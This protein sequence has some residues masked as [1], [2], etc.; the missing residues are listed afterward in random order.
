ME[1]PYIYKAEGRVSKI[2]ERD[3]WVSPEGTVFPRRDFDITQIH[4]S[5]YGKTTK[6]I[7][8]RFNAFGKS[9]VDM[10]E[11][12]SLG[13]WVE[14]LFYII[15]Y[16]WNRLDT[17]FKDEWTYNNLFVYEIHKQS[18]YAFDIEEWRRQQAELN[19]EN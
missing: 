5:I 8:I 6:E 19:K 3:D 10:A 16:N 1:R 4:Q 15:G 11:S 2:Y 13:E 14:V 18:D 12:L 17:Q 9:K 7:K